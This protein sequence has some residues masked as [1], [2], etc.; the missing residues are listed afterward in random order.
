VVD[1]LAATTLAERARIKRAR[2]ARQ[3]LLEGCSPLTVR[4]V[5]TVADEVHVAAGDVLVEQGRHGLWFFLIH[6]GRAEAVRNSRRVSELGPGNWFGEAAVLRQVP[7]PA[8][9]RAVSDMTLYVI[10]CQRLV[11]LVRDVRLLRRRLGDVGRR[12]R[13]VRAPA[14]RRRAEVVRRIPAITIDAPRRR[15]RTGRWLVAGTLGAALAGAAVYHPPLAVVSPGPS[16]DVSAD[17]TIEGVATTPPHG[18]YVVSTVR[19]S[20]PTLLG[21]GLSL[22]HSHRRVVP[23]KQLTAGGVDPTTARARGEAAF[24]ESQQMAAAAGARA[25]GLHV[26][27]SGTGAR[28]DDVTGAPDADALL[29]GDVVV[30]VADQPVASAGDVLAAVASRPAGTTWA[31][32]VERNRR[33]RIV[34]ATSSTTERAPVLLGVTFGTRDLDIVLPF[35]VHFR[36]RPIVG[37]SAGLAYALVIEDML[38]PVDLARGRAVAATGEVA[39]EGTVDAVGYV[40]QKAEAAHRAGASVLLLPAVESTDAWGV[41]LDVRGVGSLDEALAALRRDAATTP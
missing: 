29:P 32:A 8:T 34:H 24:R 4:R 10:G 38:D 27:I 7:Q 40:S 12:P 21:L 3:P 6:S 23:L 20:Q 25:A 1:V 2:L 16:F 39:P 15:H 41:G 33:T 36:P 28:V 31:L 13:L 14:L 37:P 30:K 9:V 22:L 18:R 35:T 26:R 17:V 11:P 19:A 5:A